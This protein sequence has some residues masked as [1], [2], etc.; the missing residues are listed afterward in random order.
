MET[1]ALAY[2]HR[3]HRGTLMLMVLIKWMYGESTSSC[4]HDAL[5]H[6]S[7]KLSKCAPVS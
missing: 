1:K 5:V 7:S 4:K 3:P 6:D 2:I